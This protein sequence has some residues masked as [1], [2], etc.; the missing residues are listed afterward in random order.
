[1]P[2]SFAAPKGVAEY[3]PP[4]TAGFV[5]VRDGLLGPARLAGY[6]DIEL[7]IFEDTALFAR[8]VGESTD[9]V[10]KEMFTFSD[11]GG[12]SL[13]LRPEATA[14]VVRAVL[15]HH[16]HRGQLPVKLAYAGPF[17][18][19]ERPQGG[20][21]R[22][23][24]QVD[25][26]AIGL[27]DPAVDAEVIALA[28]DGYR[29]LGLSGVRLELNSLGDP[30]CRPAYRER[31]GDFL[32][33]LDLDEDTR[34]RAEVNPLRVLDDKRPEVQA[35]LAGAP[36]MSDHLCADCKEHYDEVRGL[37][38]D[39]GVG[40]TEAPRLVRG[41]DYYTRTTFELVHGGL[42]AQAAVGGGGRYDGL[43]EKLGGPHLPAIGWALG[44]DRT[45]LAL[46]AEGASTPA[47]S[48]P[49]VFVVPLGSRA[50]H[51][52]VRLVA[53]LREARLATDLA[54]GDRGLKGAM[55]AADKSGAEVALILGER[56]LDAGVVQRKYLAGGEQAAV[57][58]EQIVTELAGGL[59]GRGPYGQDFP[60]DVAGGAA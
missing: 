40:F 36:L 4:E 8:G 1:M 31:L 41:L 19:A 2:P 27:D 43:A 60:G 54:Y 20:R 33:G 28:M 42:G 9:V 25:A 14:Q 56:D 58:L 13:T 15:E 57:P 38:G 21:F 37:L 30:V 10:T 35:Q 59:G 53:E 45:L 50:K 16:L 5:A 22:Q 11:R 52:A 24:H 26:E 32:R 48:P 39:L 23:F 29:R 44:V 12:R 6:A 17:F 51:R 55:K 7:P 18:R 3:V 49:D 34:R 46:R 47:P